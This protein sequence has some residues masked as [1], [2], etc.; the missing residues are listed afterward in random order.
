MMKSMMAVAAGF[1]AVAVAATPAP[2]AY[3]HS[4]ITLTGA[5]NGRHVR[6]HRGEH[7]IVRLSVDLRRNP[8]PATWWRSITESGPALR[9]RPQTLFLVRGVTRSS[10]QAVARGEATLSSSRA[11]CPP[12]DHSPTCF[13][14]QGWSVTVDV[15]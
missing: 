12:S 2:A 3:P 9:V 11:A 1:A 7:V 4:T 15:R 14:M 5:D 8:D 6:V 13:A 10:Y